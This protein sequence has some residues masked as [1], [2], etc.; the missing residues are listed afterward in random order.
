MLEYVVRLI[1]P[2]VADGN[3]PGPLVGPLFEALDRSIKGAVR[4]ALEGRSAARGPLPQWLARAA[5]FDLVGVSDRAATLRL[6]AP[7]LEEA[8]P[9][10]F[11]QGELFPDPYADKTAL[12]L[13]SESL[14]DALHGRAES[15]MYDDRLLG[16]FGDFGQVLKQGVS[17]VEIR[18]GRPSTPAVRIDEPGLRTVERLHEELPP[19]RSV[20]LAGRLNTIRY[21]DR[22]FQLLLPGGRKI[23]G[24]LTDDAPGVLAPLFGQP[25]VVSGLAHFRPSGS[26][27]RVDAARIAPASD[28]DL[29]VWSEAP[30]APSAELDLR[31]LRKSQGSRSGINAAIGSWED[32]ASDEEIFRLLDETS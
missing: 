11:G 10:R 22:A 25:A 13:L 9:E 21:S 32:D 8:L 28:A 29:A 27:I 31:A 4:L 1:G 20:R 24:V 3:I 26:L 2:G 23:R 12:A 16:T 7:T 14:D 15:E 6:Q 30:N 18:N 5:A 17:A 19:A